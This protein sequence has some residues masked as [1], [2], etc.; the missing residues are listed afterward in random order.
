MALNSKSSN[1][2]HGSY[3]SYRNE[4]IKRADNDPIRVYVK[5]LDIHTVYGDLTIA[6]GWG[7]TQHS[8]AK[9][10]AVL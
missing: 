7:L 6:Y 8:A 10:A 4:E 9:A 2:V 5:P 1:W 3:E